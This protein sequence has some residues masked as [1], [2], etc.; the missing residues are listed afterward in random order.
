MRQPSGGPVDP[1]VPGEVNRPMNG[2]SV[3]EPVVDMPVSSR[4]VAEPSSRF[5]R[6]ARDL[7]RFV[8]HLLTE[9]P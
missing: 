4:P 9:A 1:R 7:A 5:M 6:L 3:L 8:H 2:V